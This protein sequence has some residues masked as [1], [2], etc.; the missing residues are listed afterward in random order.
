M[1]GESMTKDTR[2][3][4]IVIVMATIAI[5]GINKSDIAELRTEVKADIAELRTEVCEL[6][7]LLFTHTAGHS[8]S[9]KTTADNG[10]Q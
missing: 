5:I 4:I 3:I 2:T 6:R 10:K 1:S 9:P 7:G 8:H